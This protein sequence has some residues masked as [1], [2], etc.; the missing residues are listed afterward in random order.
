MTTVVG[1][2]IDIPDSIMGL[3]F[4]AAG[5]NMPEL[6]SIVILAKQGKLNLKKIFF[7]SKF[8]IYFVVTFVTF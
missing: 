1:D 3:T 4:L 6:A 7:V 8:L 2:T 5:G